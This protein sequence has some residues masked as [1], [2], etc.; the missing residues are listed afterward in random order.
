MRASKS[1]P[2][3][4]ILSRK[5]ASISMPLIAI[6]MVTVESHAALSQLASLRKVVDKSASLLPVWLKYFSKS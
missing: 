3:L 6:L 4:S 5:D 2:V 1:W